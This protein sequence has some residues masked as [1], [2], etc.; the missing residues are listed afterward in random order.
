MCRFYCTAAFICVQAVIAACNEEKSAFTL[1]NKS[2]STSDLCPLLSAK[3][4]VF[5]KP[6]SGKNLS[7]SAVGLLLPVFSSVSR[8]Y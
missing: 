6:K 3:C 1:Q 8:I 5:L 2:I 7:G 4:H